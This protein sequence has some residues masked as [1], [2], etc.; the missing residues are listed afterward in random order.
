MEAS[1]IFYPFALAVSQCEETYVEYLFQQTAIVKTEDD[2]PDCTSSF[3]S[4]YSCMPPHG[5]EMSVDLL[6]G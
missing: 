5:A 4:W 1:V 2:G 3:A 6:V